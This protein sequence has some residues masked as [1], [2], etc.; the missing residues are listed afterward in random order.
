MCVCVCVGG[1]GR[2]QAILFSFVISFM[3]NMIAIAAVVV[4]RFLQMERLA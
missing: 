2:T 4:R 3:T 1:G